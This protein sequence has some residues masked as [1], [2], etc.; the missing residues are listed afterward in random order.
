[1]QFINCEHIINENG[2]LV[3]I[4]NEKSEARAAIPYYKNRYARKNTI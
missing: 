3:I 2:E 1:M 4:G